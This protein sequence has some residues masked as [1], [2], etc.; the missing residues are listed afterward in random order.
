MRRDEVQN[1]TTGAEKWV[2]DTG[3]E[4]SSTPAVADEVVYVSRDKY[5][6][7]LDAANEA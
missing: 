5:V 7:A 3:G 6:Y 2:L 4:V 1:A